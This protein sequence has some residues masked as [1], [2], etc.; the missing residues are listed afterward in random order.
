MSMLGL[1][2]CFHKFI[3]TNCSNNVSAKFVNGAI[4]QKR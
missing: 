4:G 1:A 2:E 3:D